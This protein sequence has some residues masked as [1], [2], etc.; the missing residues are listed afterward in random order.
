MITISFFLSN[1]HVA[2][3]RTAQQR[4][5][6]AV[7]EAGSLA[8]SVQRSGSRLPSCSVAR[9][10]PTTR[11]SFFQ[12]KSCGG[13]AGQWPGS[14]QKVA[15]VR[16]EV[17]GQ[18]STWGTSYRL[19]GFLLAGVFGGFSRV[20]ASLHVHGIDDVEEVLHHRHPLQGWVHAGDAVHTLSVARR[21]T[22]SAPR[23]RN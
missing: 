14:T 13:S 23:N 12:N 16:S 9:T 18:M 6:L 17:G 11:R 3:P 20:G 19:V 8:A 15:S 10:R 22:G 1:L 2:L 5:V 21:R 4:G 7:L